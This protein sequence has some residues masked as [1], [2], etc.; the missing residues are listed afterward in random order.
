MNQKQKETRRFTL[1]IILAMGIPA[2]VGYGINKYYNFWEN[3]D[4]KHQEEIRKVREG[5]AKERR[6]NHEHQER[7]EKL[8]I[9]L[10]EK[11]ENSEKIQENINP[12]R[13]ML[14]LHQ[15]FNKFNNYLKQNPSFQKDFDEM[16]KSQLELLKEDLK[17]I[18]PHYNENI[19]NNILEKLKGISIRTKLSPGKILRSIVID[20]QIYRAARYPLLP[21]SRFYDYGFIFPNLEEDLKKLGLVDEINNKIMPRFRKLLESTTFN[22]RHNFSEYA[23]RHFHWRRFDIRLEKLPESLKETTGEKLQIR[24]F[25]HFFQT[26]EKS[27]LGYEGI[28]PIDIIEHAKVDIIQREMKFARRQM[29]RENRD[30]AG[31]TIKD[32]RHFKPL[33]IR[34][35][36][37]RRA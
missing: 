18:C 6:L 28:N 36:H 10:R 33:A 20:A 7:I 3:L 8:E 14:R 30:K 37:G 31:R 21:E 1:A 5:T 9:N 34:T 13:I 23:K 15:T 2:L 22:N 16:I 32:R 35:R 26:I 11:Q 12:E 17:S 24:S 29:E 25:Y 27:F 4:L 19:V